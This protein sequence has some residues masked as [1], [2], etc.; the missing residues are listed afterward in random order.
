MQFRNWMCPTRG[1]VS[2]PAAPLGTL[3]GSGTE[4]VGVAG[5]D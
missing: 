2:T 1:L 3:R 4:A 5:T